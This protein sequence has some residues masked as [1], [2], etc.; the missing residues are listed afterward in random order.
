MHVLVKGLA[1][2]AAGA[3]LGLFATWASVVRGMGGG[4]IDDGPWHTNL[5]AGSVASGPY[6]RASVAVHGLLALDRSETI[7]YMAQRDSAG[8]ALD[9]ACAYLIVGRDP[10]TRWW[11]ITAY[12]ADDYL[13]PGTDGHYSVS[14]NSILRKDDGSFAATVSQA[15]AGANWIAVRPGRFS[16]TLRLYNPGA[17]VTADRAHAALPT[18]SKIGCR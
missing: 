14:K 17:R 10:P 6:L 13:I 18:L 7:Y 16:L 12:G 5:L 15:P 2:L 8:N 11:S 4:G 3:A 9:G 1:T